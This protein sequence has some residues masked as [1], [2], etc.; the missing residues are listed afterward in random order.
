MSWDVALPAGLGSDSLDSGSGSVS[1]RGNWDARGPLRSSAASGDS[2]EG[3]DE[4]RAGSNASSSDFEFKTV[5][6]LQES[7]DSRESE[8]A[9]SVAGD[10]G[11]ATMKAAHA[12]GQCKPCRFFLLK[13]GR[14][15]LGY[16]C[17]FCHFCTQEQAKAEQKRLKYQDRREK[18]QGFKTKKVF[19]C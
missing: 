17:S 8:P 3:R 2:T 16:A 4:G 13:G 12:E 6:G 7:S 10:E 5:P 11:A 9:T 19:E 14:C 18:R 1:L 15:H